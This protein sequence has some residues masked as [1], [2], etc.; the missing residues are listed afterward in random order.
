MTTDEVLLLIGGEAVV[1]DY[2]RGVEPGSETDRDAMRA[3]RA[4]IA[5]MRAGGVC[6]VMAQ[7][8][9]ELYGD[10]CLALCQMRTDADVQSAPVLARQ[11]SDIMLL[12]RTDN[13]NNDDEGEVT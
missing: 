7:Y 13:R 6:D 2:L 11:A 1:R 8:E 12:L 3:M 10:A 4:A 5:R 9:P